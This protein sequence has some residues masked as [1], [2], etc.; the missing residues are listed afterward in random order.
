MHP[1]SLAFRIFDQP[2]SH[3]LE[4]LTF[5]NVNA[6]GYRGRM[7][8]IE[9]SHARKL[10]DHS[11]EKEGELTLQ[12]AGVLSFGSWRGWGMKPFAER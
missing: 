10:Q 3:L 2:S 7:P 1:K 4:V 9:T 8:L 6:H 5:L 11:Y 12:F